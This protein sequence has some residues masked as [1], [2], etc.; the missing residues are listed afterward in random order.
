[1]NALM[2]GRLAEEASA[3]VS[4]VLGAWATARVLEKLAEDVVGASTAIGAAKAAG[5]LRTVLI[6][7]MSF[8]RCL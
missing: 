4:K 6:V 3:V 5:V 8:L 2:F 7:L 1:M